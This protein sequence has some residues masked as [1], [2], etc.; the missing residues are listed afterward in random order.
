LL[1]VPLSVKSKVYPKLAFGRSFGE[2]EPQATPVAM[3]ST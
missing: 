2:M 3:E 1:E